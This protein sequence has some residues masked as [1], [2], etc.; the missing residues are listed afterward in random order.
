MSWVA[1]AV[2]V[3]TAA[4]GAYNQYSQKKDAEENAAEIFGSRPTVA[5]YIPTDLSVEQ[6]KA[7]ASNLANA[8]QIEAFLNRI[9]PG[10]SEMMKQGSA[11]TLDLLRGN[12]PQDVQDQIYRSGA[13]KGLG[14]GDAWTRSI[15]ARDLGNTSLGLQQL[16]ENSAQKWASMAQGAFKPY[17]ITT[18]DQVGAAFANSAGQ[19]ATA[20]Y[21]ANVAAAPNPAAAGLFN[22][23]AAGNASTNQT[24]AL[25]NSAAQTYSDYQGGGGYDQGYIAGAYGG[26][27]ASSGGSW[28]VNPYTGRYEKLKWGSA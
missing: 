17:A 12:I 6:G 11:N 3:G 24:L 18:E 5:P 2:G 27:D 25:L 13:F 21:A 7:A 26:S 23:T 8:D 1:L 14:Q 10:W 9:T 16:G 20:Q 4:Y 19:Q 28:Q 22:V 15:V